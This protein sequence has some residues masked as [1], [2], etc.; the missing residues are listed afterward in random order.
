MRHTHQDL[1]G[2]L[3]ATTTNFKLPSYAMPSA[4]FFALLLMLLFL[5]ITVSVD[6]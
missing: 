1:R 5:K 2:Y 6:F 3:R 4:A